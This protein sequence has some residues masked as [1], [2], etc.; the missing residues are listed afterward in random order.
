MPILEAQQAKGVVVCNL[1]DRPGYSGV[2]NPLYRDAKTV[3]LLG[4]AAETL[5]RLMERVQ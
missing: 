4:D 1:D 2:D 3:L 5:A